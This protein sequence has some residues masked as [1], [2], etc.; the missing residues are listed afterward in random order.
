M[1]TTDRRAHVEF[2]GVYTCN[3]STT[4]RQQYL[5]AI[6]AYASDILSALG[7]TYDLLEENVVN[8]DQNKVATFHRKY[9]QQID[10]RNNAEIV[11][12]T[13][14][15]TRKRVTISGMYSTIEA[16]SS[17]FAAYTANYPA[18]R[19]AV[20]GAIGGTFQ[21]TT[22]RA[23]KNDTDLVTTFTNVYDEMKDGRQD[24]SFQI[25]YALDRRIS[26]FF[27]A[28]YF[29]GITG[30]DAFALAKTDFPTWALGILG[31]IGGTFN[32]KSESYQ[33]NDVVPPNYCPARL[34][35]LE[36]YTSQAGALPHPSIRDQNY[37]VTP[38]TEAP[39]DSP[40][41]GVQRM[42]E[43]MVDYVAEVDHTVSTN[44]VGIWAAIQNWIVGTVVAQYKTGSV[45]VMQ[46]SPSYNPDNNIISARMKMWIAPSAILLYKIEITDS[47]DQGKVF[48]GLWT[49]NIMNFH[50]YDG[51]A[52]AL[53]RV[54]KTYRR[55]IGGAAPGPAMPIDIHSSEGNLFSE[56]GAGEG[57]QDPF[58]F[59][60]MQM[61]IVHREQPR[62]IQTT[63]GYAPNQITVEDITFTVVMRIVEAVSGTS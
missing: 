51:H 12:E 25:I 42:I 35:F 57:N 27:Y 2:D 32:K 23:E 3:G 13:L 53:R 8:D 33:P 58:S 52:I 15:N 41:V 40:G 17:S 21:E 61:H 37:K 34:E 46:I 1:W 43:I 48:D 36:A 11:I 50:V 38:T 16:A 59:G 39:G 26:V 30:V 49:G 18:F 20:L 6:G 45:A 14:P 5:D 56:A 19:D 44:L 47:V 7:G 54:T 4:A 9:D 55:T 31:T 29:T 10:G 22:G 62:T 60:S 24:G 28:T 63:L